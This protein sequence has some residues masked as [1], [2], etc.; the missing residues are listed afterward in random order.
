M[1]A[2]LS[3][4]YRKYGSI[5]FSRCRRLLMDETLAEQATQEIFI[6]L[7]RRHAAVASQGAMLEELYRITSQHCHRLAQSPANPSFLSA[8]H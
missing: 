6:R 2:E 8:A 3:D 4:H 1:E 5:I 7:M